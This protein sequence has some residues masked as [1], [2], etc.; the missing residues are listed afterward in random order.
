MAQTMKPGSDGASASHNVAGTLKVI[1]ECAAEAIRIKGMRKALNEEM[2]EVRER[3]RDN[4]VQTKTFDLAVKL[5]EMEPE[6]QGEYIDSLRLNFEALSI[7]GQGEMFLD[8]VGED[9]PQ[10][11]AAAREAAKAAGEAAGEAGQASSDNPHKATD[12]L[13]GD[14]H[15]GWMAATRKR[16]EE[17]AP[18]NAPPAPAKPKRKRASK[19]RSTPTLAEAQE[20]GKA[21][22]IAGQPA[23][24]NPHEADTRLREYWAAAHR[25]HY[26]A[27]RAGARAPTS[28]EPQPPAAA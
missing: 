7:G 2:A 8:S 18:K 26:K 14:W 12:H 20:D 6:A 15:V 5:K 10:E 22:G 13:H 23:D 27:P 17:M 24:A 16:A 21:A 28:P 25:R 4:G 11:V 19:T 1:R 9:Q 3:L